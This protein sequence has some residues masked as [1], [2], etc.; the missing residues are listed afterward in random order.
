M[1]VIMYVCMYVCL[2]VC[3]YACVYVCVCVWCVCVCASLCACVCVSSYALANRTSFWMHF[4]FAWCAGL[5]ESIH[6]LYTRSS[7]TF[8]GSSRYAA[9]TNQHNAHVHSQIVSHILRVYAAFYAYMCLRREVHLHL[10]FY[11]AS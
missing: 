3:Q 9:V 5:P 8:T 11:L 4:M 6:Y 7:F 1:Y 10:L 2:D